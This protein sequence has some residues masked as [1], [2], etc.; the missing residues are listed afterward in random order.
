MSGFCADRHY[1]LELVIERRFPAAAGTAVTAVCS[2]ADFPD[3]EC[4]GIG[5]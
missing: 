5:S 1:N 2:L 3:V 4:P